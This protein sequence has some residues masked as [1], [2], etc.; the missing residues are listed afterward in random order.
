M[1][2]QD[3]KNPNGLVLEV[4]IQ[5]HI[6]VKPRAFVGVVVNNDFIILNKNNVSGE[7]MFV[8]SVYVSSAEVKQVYSSLFEFYKRV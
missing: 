4:E 3:L 1:K 5:T 8:N 2:V 7:K 6:G